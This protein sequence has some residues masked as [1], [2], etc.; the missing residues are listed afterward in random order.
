MGPTVA[1][2]SRGAIFSFA[3]AW[4]MKARVPCGVRYLD[5]FHAYGPPHEIRATAV[6]RGLDVAGLLTLHAWMPWPVRIASFVLCLSACAAP[7]RRS[8]RIP[9]VV[10]A[11]APPPPVHRPTFTVHI[12][13]VGTG[14][15]VFVEGEDFA[16]VY[17]AGSNDDTAIEE[18]NRFMADLRAVKP[19]LK[20]IDHVVLS[21]PHRDHVELLPDVIAD[22][23]IAN[24]WDSGAVNPICGYRRF[25]EVISKSSASYHSGVN[26]AGKHKIDFG[27]VVCK[28]P[29]TVTIEHAAKMQEGEPRKLGDRATMTFLH[30]DGQRHGDDFNQNSLVTVL[31]L[32]GV[33]VLL[34]GDAEAGGREEPSQP[35]TA[36]SIEGYV[37]ATYRDRIRADVL[38]A[39]H[40][41][42]K[43]SSRKVFI[44]AVAP[45][46]SVISSGPTKYQTVVL[47]DAVI[48]EE[49][50]NAGSLFETDINDAACGKND[51]KI[52]PDA[53]G[54]P[55]GCDNVQIKIHDGAVKAA[56][57]KVS[58]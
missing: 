58:D 18:K 15:A 23:Q 27:E 9:P 8:P 37:L 3:D 54:N 12:A 28:L 32:D 30:V 44:D 36:K 55:G 47:P 29:A 43:S 10:A 2:R 24:I 34:M 39:G 45:K 33:R 16:F 50:K 20:K 7:D 41:G 21:H 22:Y 51:K 56:Y 1:T 5:E 42:S 13:D 46:V 57:E 38:I 48:V 4:T 25:L 14:L 35:P 40:H 52:G 53:D 11:P 6:S 49:L 17:D 19:D 31:D 26:D